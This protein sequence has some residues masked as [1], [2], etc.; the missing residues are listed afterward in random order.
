M[1]D[2]S[3]RQIEAARPDRS[4]WLS[5]NAGSGKT[6]VLTDRVARL[7]LK[8]TPPQNILCLTYTKAAASEM[9]NR[10]FKRLGVWAMMPDDPLRTAL[11]DLGEPA[12]GDADLAA[13]RRLFALAIETP[14]GLRIQTIHSFCAA[15]LRRFPLEA[16]VSPDFAEMDDRTAAQLRA[17]CLEA[18][19]ETA[20]EAVRDAARLS[21]GP[22][23]ELAQTVAA[24]RDRFAAVT[25]ADLRRVLDL[26][27]GLERD[28]LAARV[29]LGGEDALFARLAG[30]MGQGSV[31]D[32]KDAGRFAGLVPP[33]TA[34]TL[35]ILEGCLLTGAGARSPY[36][37]KIDAYPTRATRAALGGDCAALNDLMRRV[38]DARTARLAL[39]TLERSL[40]L[41]R[42]A[43]PWLALYRTRK[44]ALGWLD[45]DDLILGAR[46]L[47]TRPE[48]AEWVLYRLDGG[49]DHIL[50]DEA[51]DTSPAQ[52]Q[53]IEALARE[54]ASGHG[55]RGAGERSI[56]VVGDKKQSIYSFQGAD[57]E[58]FDRMHD[59]FS[60]QLGAEGMARLELQHSFRSSPA[61]LRAVDAV[62]SAGL[63]SGV[64]HLAFHDALPG[65]VDLWSLHEEQ[66][67]PQDTDW[68]DPLDR[69]SPVSATGTLAR[70]LADTIARMIDGHE[71]V[72]DGSGGRRRIHA[73]DILILVRGRNKLFHPIIRACKAR[74]IAIAGAD[75]LTLA[76]DLA[77]RD[78][79]SLLRFLTLPEDDL[80]LAEALRSPLLGLSEDDL[81]RL[82]QGRDGRL[83]WQNLRDSAAHPTAMAI[84]DDLMAQADFLRPF[85]LIDRLLRRHDGRARLIGRL[86]PECIDAID[87][88]LAQALD[89]ERMDVPSLTG[90][91][92]WFDAG[93]ATVKRQAE[94]GGR[95]LRVMTVHGAK[96]L[97]APVVILPD[98]V[99]GGSGHVPRFLTVPDGPVLWRPARE[100]RVP[101][102]TPLLEAAAAADDAEYDRLLYVAMTRAETWLIVCGA[103]QPADAA[104]SWYG[105]IARGLDTL[106]TA[107]LETPNGAGR[108]LASGSWDAG[109]APDLPATRDAGAP[110]VALHDWAH[111]P[112][113]PPAEPLRLVSPSGLGGAKVLDTLSPNLEADTGPEAGATLRGSRI[114]LLLEH[115]PR[116]TP[117]TWDRTARRL[118]TGDGVAEPEIADL[119][120][121]A[122]SV[123]SAPEL[124]GLFA[125]PALTEVALVADHPSGARIV[126]SVDRLI[127]A[128]DRVLA[129]DYKSNRTVPDTAKETP[130][131]LLRQM[132]AYAH[133]LAQIY[134]GRIVETALLWTR[135]PRL[136]PLDAALAAAAFA[137][138]EP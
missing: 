50:V 71:T 64:R 31:N 1:N 59:H 22:L 96:G 85:E 23:E 16:G 52:W 120:D 28:D 76:D 47:L 122:R 67:T 126:G 111:H 35:E 81:Y 93:D 21:N 134:P 60:A 51:Q 55:T 43:V 37:A 18:L 91:L 45:F 78:I 77:V 109:P 83:L 20:P 82:A 110:R 40:A 58:G 65:R 75:V 54:F 12:L 130:E 114:H 121:E 29:F 90:F 97:E 14:G 17:D 68:E 124:S 112:P 104:K 6:R 69:P 9:Q 49:I 33:W 127:V 42:F 103:G 46:H 34:S 135:V 27:D 74:G 128:P 36:T 123:L 66:E 61:I 38:E 3:R 10:L 62:F 105:Q 89:Y 101:A 108:R 117:D 5:A 73:G 57:P 113:G 87:A 70:D 129:I 41:N 95:N 92:S 136:T 107:A 13:A 26:P 94:A 102:V 131:G 15:L 100:E 137:R 39:T 25:E 86:G 132:G 119:L 53:V 115:L 118:L 7:L 72:P 56:F 99:H 106:D 32:Q 63:G 79:L 98:T 80:S 19:A 88:L 24:S 116:A 84:I 4:T 48:V 138:S 2:A 11:S 133:A 125:R 30:A 8:G 44:E